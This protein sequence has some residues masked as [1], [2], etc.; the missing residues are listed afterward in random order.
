MVIWDWSH[1]ASGLNNKVTLQDRLANFGTGHSPLRS[2]TLP[3][4]QRVGGWY[5][6]KSLVY[7]YFHRTLQPT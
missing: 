2:T 7:F 4:A 3:Y 6:I 5:K 1:D